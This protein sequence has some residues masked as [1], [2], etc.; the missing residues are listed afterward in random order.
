MKYTP[1]ILSLALL[2]WCIP[3]EAQKLKIGTYT[4]KDGSVYQG[5]LE[6]GRPSGKGRTEFKNGDVYE[7]E[8]VK[9]K[10]QGKGI[11]TFPDGEKYDGEWFQDRKSVV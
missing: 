4:F 7:G 2:I 10:R 3:L 11:Y 1:Y 5:E 9:G 8:Y 6:G